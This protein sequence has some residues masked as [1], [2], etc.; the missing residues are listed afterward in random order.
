LGLNI[1]FTANI[2]TPLDREMVL[3]H[4]RW[5]L[6]HKNFFINKLDFNV[7]RYSQNHKIAFLGHPTGASGAIQT[8]YVKVLMQRNFVAE[9]LPENASFTRKQRVSVFELPFV[10]RVDLGVMHAIRL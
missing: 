10:G 4:F 3:L 2:C 5:K 8:L 1:R 9:I 7:Q 6:S